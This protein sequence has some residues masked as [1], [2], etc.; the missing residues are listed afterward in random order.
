MTIEFKLPDLGENIESGDVVN[1]LVS[2]GDVIEEEQNVLELETD[3]AVV[4]VPCSHAGKIKKIHVEPGDTV[5]VGTTV[6]TLE[7]GQGAEKEEKKKEKKP[8][9]KEKEE[10]KYC[11][12]KRLVFS[13]LKLH[14]F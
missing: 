1:I 10:P 2:E 8:G 13:L 9:K 7:E 12:S 4:E 14:F 6:L 5:E 11:L 3:K